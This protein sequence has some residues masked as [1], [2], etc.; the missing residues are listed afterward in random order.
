MANLIERASLFARALALQAGIGKEGGARALRLLEC[1]V[2]E[3][4]SNCAPE[5]IERAVNRALRAGSLFGGLN[6]CF[7]RAAVRCRLM[8]R[9]GLEARMILGLRKEGGALDGHAWVVWPGGP[10][11]APDPANFHGV[12]IH[13]PPDKFPGWTPY[14]NSGQ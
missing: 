2:T 9:E 1:P 3:K 4:R 8:R 5:E 11:N 7:S 10:G 14:Q 6:T 13:P 12:E